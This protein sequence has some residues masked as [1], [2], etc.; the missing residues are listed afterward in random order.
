VANL[1]AKGGM[2]LPVASYTAS[3]EIAMGHKLSKAAEIE[4]TF[5]V[6]FRVPA[7][8]IASAVII[9]LDERYRSGV[10][11]ASLVDRPETEFIRGIRNVSNNER[12]VILRPIVISPNDVYAIR[13]PSQ[14]IDSYATALDEVFVQPETANDKTIELFERLDS[15]NMS[16]EH[17]AW[18]YGAGARRI[19]RKSLLN[20]RGKGEFEGL[21]RAD[22]IDDG[23]DGGLEVFPLH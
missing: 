18:I 2:C 15:Q 10:I 3:A 23:E 22:Q 16:D 8:R 14:G 5:G 12:E 11:K 17:A 20:L 21:A 19:L 13:A 6:I 9:N 1:L 4:N 7:D